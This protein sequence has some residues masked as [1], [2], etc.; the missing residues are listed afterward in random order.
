[1]IKYVLIEWP[2]SQIFMEEDWFDS[3]A[4][5]SDN[6]SYFIPI[7]RYYEFFKRLQQGK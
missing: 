6:S 5:L 4:F 7:S 1:M 3:E 2:E